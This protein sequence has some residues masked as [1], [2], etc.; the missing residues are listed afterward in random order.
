MQSRTIIT[1]AVL[2]GAMLSGGWLLGRGLGGDEGS[3]SRGRLFDAV[4]THVQRHFV[5]SLSEAQ[6]FDHALNGMLAELDDPYTQY[7]SPDRFRRLTESTTGNYAGVGA[8]IDL[9]DRWPTV[10]AVRSGTPAERAGLASG[11]RLV[12]IAG[13]RTQ[14]WT[15][16]EAVRALRGPS[17]TSVKLLVE[18]PAVR[19]QIPIE[20]TRS[21]IHRRAVGRTAILAGG[22]GYVDVN[23]FHDS[24]AL[25]IERSVDSLHT[26]G[27]RSLL[28]DLRSNPGGL[29]NQ[30][31][32]VADLFLDPGTPIVSLRG[33]VADANREYADTSAQRWPKL[34]LVVLIDDRSASAA[35]LV[36]GA[37]QDHDRALIVGRTSYGKGSAQS[38]YRTTSGGA[39]RITT[40][41]W[42]TP[43]GRS[44]DRTRDEASDDEAIGADS[45][46]ERQRYRTKG[47]R[48]V[49]GGGGITPDVA[50]G[51]TALTP[52][53]EALQNALGARVLDFRDAMTAYAI[54]L[55]SSGAIRTPEFDVT[56][57]M[58][59]DLRR[60]LD[61][62]ALPIPT[63]VYDAAAPT[64]AR[65]L[66]REIARYVFGADEV[67]RRSI[68]DDAVIQVAVGIASGAVA[69]D[70]LF[71]RAL[72]RR[73]DARGRPG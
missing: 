4:M 57:R 8:Q 16:D 24:T 38:V 12:D 65:L 10:I 37:L 15:V 51:D 53:E 23:I 26:S 72:A 1:A 43:V 70:D 64:I 33:R 68:R 19:E 30:G 17:G 9:R 49:L 13:Q 28:L 40:G 73:R 58:L 69:Q 54:S 20:L 55:K 34:P 45:I 52:E 44:I 31:L 35:E 5:D 63:P 7:L 32:A 11:D 18:R 22:I 46:D 62:R 29:L 71:R 60:L 41:R 56:R 59:D 25:E 67:A 47:G 27:I 50:A 39:L 61:S 2:G 66:A 3:Y 14:G 21:E 6:L 42:F 48:E 36:A